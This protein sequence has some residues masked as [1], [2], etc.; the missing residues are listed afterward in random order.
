MIDIPF[1]PNLS[2]GGMRLAWHSIFSFLALLVGS[3]V[4]FRLAR[5]LVR[6]DR[7]YLFALAVI[8]GGLA[9]ARLA[10]VADNWAQYAGRPLEIAAFWN[11]GIAVTGA[12]IGSAL[13]GLAAARALRLPVG[14]M[15]DIATLGIVVG[16]AIG[17][18]GDII[19][20]EHHAVA[21]SGLP[22]C[23]RY[24]HPATLGQPDPVHPVV[25]YDALIDVALFVVLL[26]VWYRVRGARRRR[27]SSGCT[28]A[29]TARSAS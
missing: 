14:F 15:F 18:I 26:R 27:A 24:T 17:R 25:V 8:A 21:C 10:H 3:R 6:D 7:I 20:G 28:S 16:E 1:D 23:V 11:G 22:W 5:W 29:C 12:P 2:I 19:N 9:S 13:A 4:S